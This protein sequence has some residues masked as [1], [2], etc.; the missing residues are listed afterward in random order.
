[1]GWENPNLQER[2]AAPSVEPRR[3]CLRAALRAMSGGCDTHSGDDQ[4][5]RIC[6]KHVSSWRMTL[7]IHGHQLH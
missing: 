6:K 4:C 1:M 7:G 3:P 2:Q 5:F